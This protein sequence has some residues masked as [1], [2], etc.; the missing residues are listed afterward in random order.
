[1]TEDLEL[2]N[3]MQ[4]MS[5][6]VH[7]RASG[8]SESDGSVDF[9]ENVFVEYIL[10]RLEEMGIIE[11]PEVCHFE[12]RAQ[13]SS[14]RVNGFAVN[15]D[16]DTLDLFASIFLDLQQPSNVS[17]EDITRAANEAIRFFDAA[18]KGLHQQMETASDAFGMASRIYEVA[19]T[20]TRARIFVL[21]DGM[22][23]VRDIRGAKI[24]GLPVLLEVEIWDAGRLFRSMQSVLPRDVIEIDFESSF[25]A[26][27]PCLAMPR[28]PEDYLSYL[29]IMP[30]EILY[31]IY[32]EYGPRLLEFNV[33]SFLQA[34]GKVNR[35]IRDTLKQ[36]PDR[37]M[38]YN[39]GISATADSL[40]VVRNGDGQLA[41][42]SVTG[43]QIVNG[44]QTT[45][46][47]HRAK[48]IDKAAISGVFV[49]AKI[50]TLL[51]PEKLEGIVPK[52]SLYA[53]SQ[54]KIDVA[55]FSA[56]HSFHIE[57]ERLSTTVW[58]PGEQGR[59]FYERARGQYQV[60]KSREGTTPAQKRKFDERTPASR[61]F[62]KT[63]LA[64]YVNTWDQLPNVV[65]RGA[66][67]NFLALTIEIQKRGKDWKPD[68]T[69][70]REL[71]AKAIIF[72]Q[73]TRIVRQEEFPA[74]KAN[75]VTYLIAYLAFRS[76]SSLS[77]RQIWDN[78]RISGELE[79]LLRAWSH[80]IND[81]ITTSAGGRN[82]TEWCKKE[83]CWEAICRTDTQ[84]PDVLPPEWHIGE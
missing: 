65:S 47:L 77:L 58:C 6:E 56:N 11:N 37:F 80:R 7:D 36:E 20:L 79:T 2:L 22:S 78:Q 76:G 64:K 44:G 21:T 83:E 52:I 41:I 16:G 74:Y 24:R 46:S 40:Q 55:D 45:A 32:D 12:R 25:G 60:A 70:Y 73:A 1:M 84:L 9:K 66:Q 3:F 54:N 35:G 30:A 15:D 33:R 26:P 81:A 67:K 23:R 53:N 68:E 17:K 39:N 34:K 71:I 63:G 72:K 42:R 61:R 59:W 51:K 75:I 49:P 19:P 48:K 29:T 8:G 50:T 5:S 18:R 82:V 28:A 14:L 10:E 27:I 31:R 62:T 13:R 4:R 69:W 43:L 38:A 57:I